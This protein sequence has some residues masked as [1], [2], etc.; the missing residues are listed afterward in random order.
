MKSLNDEYC[1]KINI[2]VIVNIIYLSISNLNYLK[3][4]VYHNNN[5][6]EN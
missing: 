6:I 2:K 1:N 3:Y 5:L 4:S